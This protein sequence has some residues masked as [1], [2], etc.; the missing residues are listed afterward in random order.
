MEPSQPGGEYHSR[1]IFKVPDDQKG[2]RRGTQSMSPGASPSAET[3]WSVLEVPAWEERP[4]WVVSGGWWGPRGPRLHQSSNHCGHISVFNNQRGVT[5][6]RP[7]NIRP[8]PQGGLVTC[9][10]V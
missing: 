5:G 1:V 7:L 4:G 3:G 8:R 9:D 6:A 2:G 10:E